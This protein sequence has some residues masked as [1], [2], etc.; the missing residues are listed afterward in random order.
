VTTAREIV[1]DGLDMLM[2]HAAE[3]PLTAHQEQ[4]GLRV[5]N[6]LIQSASLEHFLIYYTPAVQVHWPSGKAMLTWGVGGDIVTTPRP[7]QL[8]THATYYDPVPQT[9]Y[10]LPVV[11]IAEY[12]MLTWPTRTGDPLQV[13]SY[14]AN[15]PLGELYAYPIPQSA[16]EVT[17]YPWLILPAWPSFD[18]EVLLPP[19][20]E[21]YLKAAFACDVAPYYDREPSPI[22]Q[23]IRM[24]AR[25]R[26]KTVNLTIP[27]LDVPPFADPWGMQVGSSSDIRSWPR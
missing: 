15:Y 4:Q 23:G 13:L 11:P 6:D 14:A 24:E 25:D 7:V 1:T 26:L 12:R 3:E 10:P 9:S 18:E 21:R 19:G 5:L 8:A 20:Y 16:V 27:T 2:V 17:V 22:V